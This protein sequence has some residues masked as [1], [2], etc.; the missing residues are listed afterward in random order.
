MMKHRGNVPL[1]SVTGGL[2]AIKFARHV[3]MSCPIG[4]IGALH[5]PLKN[6]DLEKQDSGAANAPHI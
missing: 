2:E 6:N 5:A 3:R 1:L 4:H